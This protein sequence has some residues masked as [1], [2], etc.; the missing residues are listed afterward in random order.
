MVGKQ[1]CGVEGDTAYV[2]LMP[3]GRAECGLTGTVQMADLL[4]IAMRLEALA[5]V[6]EVS[7]V[8]REAP[9]KVSYPR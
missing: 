4:G 2:Q 7:P 8:V 1:C 3:D 5:N 6:I 9:T